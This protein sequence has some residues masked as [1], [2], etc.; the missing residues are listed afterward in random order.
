MIKAAIITMAG[1]SLFGASQIAS[2]ATTGEADSEENMSLELTL[3]PMALK[4]DKTGFHRS[5]AQKPGFSASLKLRS[6]RVIKLRF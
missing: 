1:V 4:T 2:Q 5:A 3:G 6:G